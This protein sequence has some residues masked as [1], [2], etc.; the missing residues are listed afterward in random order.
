MFRSV[1]MITALTMTALACSSGGTTSNAPDASASSPASASPGSPSARIGG[2]NKK[3]TCKNESLNKKDA[4]PRNAACEDCEATQCANET[5]RAVGTDPNTFGGSCGEYLNCTCDCSVTD[6]SCLFTCPNP[7][8]ACTSEI[9]AGL[10]CAR[11]KC[12]TECGDDF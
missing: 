1:S 5:A 3:S 7:S 10:E 9:K 11:A 8:D 6:K 2:I 12:A 4:G